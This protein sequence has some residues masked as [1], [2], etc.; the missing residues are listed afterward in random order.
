M[1]EATAAEE[2]AVQEWRNAGAGNE[3]Y[4]RQ[5]QEVWET[6]RQLVQRS[7]PD[8]NKAWE[9]FR[10]RIGRDIEVKVIPR[11]RFP[12]WRIAAAAVLVAVVGLAGYFLA[13]NE[14]HPQQ[15]IVEATRQVVND[16][17]PDGSTV[18]LNTH[19][20]VSYPEQFTGNTRNI[21]L[22]GEAFFHVAPD[23]SKPFIIHVNDIE[24][25]VVGT[26]FNIKSEAA[27]TEVVV[28]TGIVRVKRG[29][30]IIELKAGEKTLVPGSDSIFAKEAVTDQLYNYYRTREF[31]CDSTPLWKLVEVLNEAYG[32]HII[33]GRAGLR[34]L[35]I[36][37]TFFN[38]SLEQVLQVI[39]LT[40]DITVSRKGDQIILSKQVFQ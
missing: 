36:S 25:T 37:T 33:V 29:H 3:R 35:P 17:L 10:Q 23:Q 34:A 18:T 31:V 21:A 27:G 12:R 4:F 22:K 6:S 16:T 1:G 14:G 15:L 11:R 30:R 9:R 24:V 2:Q 40:F 5:L 28:E 38:E 26:S 19:S 13:R 32:A 39:S 20:S 8:E 7:G